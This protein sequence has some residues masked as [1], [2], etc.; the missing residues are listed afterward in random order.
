[1]FSLKNEVR[2]LS[3]KINYIEE[4][5]LTD[6]LNSSWAKLYKRNFL[7]NN[8]IQFPPNV[9]IGEDAIFVGNA[10]DKCESI[11]FVSQPIYNYIDNE[12]SAIHKRIEDFNDQESLYQFKESLFDKYKSELNIKKM[13]SY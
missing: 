12:N 3:N 9:A 6:N 11:S 7:I 10:L 8:S 13:T 2:K 5:I 4:Y 1:M